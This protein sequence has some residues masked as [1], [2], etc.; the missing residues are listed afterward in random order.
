MNDTKVKMVDQ[1]EDTQ[2]EGSNSLD[3]EYQLM[4]WWV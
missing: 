4:P 1:F 3:P 2:E